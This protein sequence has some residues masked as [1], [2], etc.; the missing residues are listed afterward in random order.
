MSARTATWL[1]WSTCALFLALT[2]LS[3]LLLRLN[4]SNPGVPI[5]D[6]WIP[7]TLVALGFSPVGAFIASHLSPKNPMGGCSAR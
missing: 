3:L 5:Y 1:A 6:F 4:L 2:A 7:N